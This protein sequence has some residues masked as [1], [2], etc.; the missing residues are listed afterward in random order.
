MRRLCAATILVAVAGCSPR[1]PVVAPQPSAT[2]RLV[3]ADAQLRAGCLE[4]LV[5]AYEQYDALRQAAGAANAA[6]AGAI[7]AAALVA[8]RERELGMIDDGYL[9]KAREL[10]AADPRLPLSV[11]TLLDIVDVLPAS[12][13]GV[14]RPAS[15]DA[16]LE[17]MR[18]LRQNRDAWTVLL[19]NAARDDIAAAYTWVALTCDAVDA[20]LFQ[21]T[22]I[23]DVVS[24]FAGA[25]L[26]VYREALCRSVDE[27]TLGSLLS[28]NGRFVEIAYS[29]GLGQLGARP[30]KLDDAD[31]WFRRA[32]DWQPKWPSLTL[33]MGGVAMSGEEFERAR[34]LY[35]E[36]LALEPHSGDA[37]FGAIRAL[38]YMG[39]A[40]AAIAMA[41]RMIDERWS[42]GDARYWRA[43]NELQ[44]SR[45]DEAWQ[46]VEEAERTLINA[47]VPKL[48]GLVAYRRQQPDI[49][50][51]RFTT[52]Y[53][54]NPLDCETR[55]YLGVVY[56][57]L[58]HWSQTSDMLVGAAECFEASERELTQ[59]IER[60]RA[61]TIS[62]DR[63]ASQI[64]RRE[65][66]IVEGRRR[67]ATSWFDIAVADFSLSKKDDARHYAE[68]VIDDEQFGERARAL[69]ARLR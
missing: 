68:K 16:D 30:P 52:S 66:Q 31:R 1:P 60:I 38:T 64:A 43:Y 45:L 34:A 29:I 33:T 32:Y 48:A 55:F 18:T 61:S 17:R 8:L 25:P 2:E 54:R 62:D 42:V 27:A 37:M 19:R 41:D 53:S 46:D 63:K 9:A 4:C 21:P 7:R 24:A 39:A 26:V 13:G 58:R 36:T 28:A 20:R 5:S 56:A 65:Q 15:S 49:A 14:V 6:T 47:Q 50:M 12:R 11:S 51:A 44:L 35:E 10:A 40:E 22:A 67:I 23:F 69:L 59:E 57:D 3:A